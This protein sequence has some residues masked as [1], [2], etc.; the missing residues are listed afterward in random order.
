M[1]QRIIGSFLFFILSDE[2][3][4]ITVLLPSS[5]SSSSSSSS[6]LSPP[7]SL[8]SPSL[9]LPLYPQSPNEQQHFQ[10]DKE[11]DDEI[12]LG[13]ELGNDSP[14][15]LPIADSSS[16][17]KI[18][19]KVNSADF[20]EKWINGL[21]LTTSSFKTAERSSIESLYLPVL[22]VSLFVMTQYRIT[23]GSTKQ[24]SDSLSYLKSFLYSDV[25]YEAPISGMLDD[26]PIGPFHLFATSTTKPSKFSFLSR[27]QLSAE[28]LDDISKMVKVEKSKARNEV[29]PSR[30]LEELFEELNAKI[31]QEEEKR[32]FDELRRKMTFDNWKDFSLSSLKRDSHSRLLYLPFHHQIITMG[33]VEYHILINRITGRT[34][35]WE[36]IHIQKKKNLIITHSHLHS[37]PPKQANDPTESA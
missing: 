2:M 3:D 35:G 5:P 9:S 11:E 10:K 23:T 13:H 37:R 17:K 14:R 7:S 30:P 34:E 28:H 24:A 16:L 32:V 20:V 4:N 31:K 29:V 26:H 22:E 21:Y 18:C 15:V 1:N 8:S 27:M 12:I 6:S 33:G 19:S 36:N 25:N